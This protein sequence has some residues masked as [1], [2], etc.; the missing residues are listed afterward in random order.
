[1]KQTFKETS[2]RIKDTGNFIVRYKKSFFHAI[3]GIIYTVLHEH[4]IPII[5]TAIIVTTFAGFY[6]DISEYEWLF[7]ILS[8][9]LVFAF[10]LVN[11]AIEALVDLVIQKHHPLAKIAKDAASSATLILSITSL[12]GGLIIFIPKIF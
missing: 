12:I 3:D 4:N 6:Y 8:M 7:C 1:M 11:T 2:N 5:L 9:G 10:E